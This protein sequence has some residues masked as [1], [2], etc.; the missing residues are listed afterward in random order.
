MAELRPHELDPSYDVVNFLSPDAMVDAS[1][2][3]REPIHLSGAIQPHG[4]L[5][6]VQEADLVIRQVSANAAAHLGTDPAALLGGPLAGALGVEPVERLRVALAAPRALNAEPLSCHLPGGA[7]YELTWHR[8]DG[9]VIIELEPA[10]V[11]GAVSMPV[12]FADVNHAMRILQEADSVQALCDSAATEIKRMTGYDRVMV[13]RFH[14]DEHGEVVAEAREPGLEPFFGLHYPATDIPR[15]ALKLYLL[16]H[17]RVIADVDY[18]PAAML[19]VADE[20]HPPLNLSL[21]G[22]RSVSPFHL[23][24]LHNMGVAATLTISL[25][26][27]TRLWGMLACHH[28]SPKRIDAQLRAA[29]RMLGQVFSLQ[30]VAQEGRERT[31]YRARLAEVQGEVLLRMTGAD[32]LATALAQS[33]PSPLLLTGADGMVA[34]IDGQIVSSGVVPPPPAVEALLTRLRAEDVPS[35]LVSDDLPRHFA[36]LAPFTTQAAGVFAL[37]LSAAYEDFVLWFRTELVHQVNWAGNPTKAPTSPDGGLPIELS[38]RQSFAT[39]VEEVRGRS[40]PWLAAEIDTGYALA[41]A[42]PELLLARTRDRFAQLA[43]QDPL[44]GLPNREVLLDRCAQA[45]GRRRSRGGAVAVLALDLDNFGLV[46]E[47]Y[48][49]AAGDSLLRAAGQR[50]IATCADTDTVVRLGGDQFGVL[51]EG[52]TLEEAHRRA[53]AIVQAFRAAFVVDGQEIFATTSIGVA[54]AEDDATPVELLRDADTAM[55]RAKR[56][57]RNA[58]A[59][60]THEMRAV[61][62]RRGD[63][64]LGLRETIELR[65]LQLDF[66]PMYDMA[67]APTGFEAL[68]RWPL[69]GRGMVPPADFIPVAEAAGLLGRVTDLVVDQGLAALARWRRQYPGRGLTLAVNITA[70]QMTSDSLER[71]IDNGLRRHDLPAGAL[72]LEIAE[73]ALVAEDLPSLGFLRRLN[74]RGVRLSIDNFGTGSASLTYLTKLPL[75]E[76]KID[77]SFTGGLPARHGDVTV[78]ASVVGLAHRLNLTAVAVGVETNEQLAAVRRLGCDVAQGYLLGRPMPAEDID[79]LL[80]SPARYGSY[81]ADRAADRA[82]GA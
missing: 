46:N 54:L 53:D 25:L 58:G 49:R 23:A 40:R 78:V 2:C 70:E 80:A 11:T 3:D 5:L 20:V 4:L 48:G 61:K 18:E 7:P 21:A 19:G 79:R 27:G 8:V 31:D 60:F 13:Y 37:P 82:A 47:T 52:I 38:P 41:A 50:L 14:P 35:A 33:D 62:V 28:G 81:G 17:L 72:C 57:G 55:H 26:H 42:V 22:L 45:L 74:E 51:C 43:Q 12:L 75:H 59:L 36:E 73:T 6:A 56:A 39:W 10:D 16:N 63:I 24:Y 65:Q 29:C 67:G 15:Q 34:R 9:L 77:R 71:S 32:S 66:Q 1:S 44:T 76:I 69:A 68:V 64:E 30:V